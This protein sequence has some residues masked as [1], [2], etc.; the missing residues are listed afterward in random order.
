MIQS[1]FDNFP[2]MDNNYGGRQGRSQGG[3]TSTCDTPWRKEEYKLTSQIGFLGRTFCIFGKTWR[4]F[5]NFGKFGRT[6]VKF[7]QI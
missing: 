6:F 3:V 7:W 2:N 4:T 5:G 1:F